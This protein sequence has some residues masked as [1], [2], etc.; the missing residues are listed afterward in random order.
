MQHGEIDLKYYVK[1]RNVPKAPPDDKAILWTALL[2]LAVK[3]SIL[4]KSN[5]S[6]I[7]SHMGMSY[8]QPTAYSAE[9]F[10]SYLPLAVAV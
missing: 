8:N 9:H 7:P 3:N 2:K 10:R 6:S 4:Q 5:V 1:I